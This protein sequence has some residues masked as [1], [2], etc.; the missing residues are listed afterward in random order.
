HLI[1]E[2]GVRHLLLA[3]RSGPDHPNAPALT[4]ELTALGAQVTITA[5]DTT[6]AD[7]VTALIAAID[8]DH[9]LTAVIHTAGVLNDTVL[10]KLT[11]DGLHSVLAPKV[12]AAYHLHRA[13]MGLDLAHFVVYSSA[14]GIL[15]NPGQANYAAA[16]TYLDAL[17][18]HRTRQGLPT[19]SLAWGYWEQA[20]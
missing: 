12:D 4:D 13:T 11:A 16:N 20:T 6:D 2:H 9:P 8:G 19:T 14:A 5:C 18:H 10:G 3:S 15:G 1:T 7:Q 17:A